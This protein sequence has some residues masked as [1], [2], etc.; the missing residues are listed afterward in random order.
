LVVASSRSGVCGLGRHTRP[1][2]RHPGLLSVRKDVARNGRCADRVYALS[3]LRAGPPGTPHPPVRRPPAPL[4]RALPASLGR[5]PRTK[6]RDNSR[7]RECG[8]VLSLV[9]DADGHDACARIDLVLASLCGSTRDPYKVFFPGMHA[10]NCRG[11]LG[12]RP[13]LEIAH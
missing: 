13:F 4:A 10:R 2:Q 8:N 5:M 7:E 3:A 1:V 6:S 12:A 11:P 9:R